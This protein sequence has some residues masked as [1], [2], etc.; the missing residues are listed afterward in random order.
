MKK[1]VVDASVLIC[2]FDRESES[3]RL[4]ERLMEMAGSGE[5]AI[6]CPDL[7]LLELSNV[8]IK[9]KKLEADK[10]IEL[11]NTLESL[12]IEFVSMRSGDVGEIAGLMRKH[13]ITAYDALYLFL[14][15]RMKVSLL[16]E[17]KELLNV[18]GCVSLKQWMDLPV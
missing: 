4:A 8:L 9:V 11:V 2:L 10:L 12:G 18:R 3:T 5:L 6:T 7:T 13:G 1:V 16:T 17:D 15:A 14:S